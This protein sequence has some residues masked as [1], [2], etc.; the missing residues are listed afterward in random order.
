M[1]NKKDKRCEQCLAC[2]R[3]SEPASPEFEMVQCASQHM[4]FRVTATASPGTSV[5]AC[6]PRPSSKLLER[7]LETCIET[8]FPMGSA[9]QCATI[10]KVIPVLV[11]KGAVNEN[12]VSCVS[13]TGR[14][15]HCVVLTVKKMWFL[16]SL[17]GFFPSSF[18][19]KIPCHVY[20]TFSFLQSQNCLMSA[21]E[22]APNGHRKYLIAYPNT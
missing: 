18:N 7:S 5:Q 10:W 6:I 14:H 8:S 4:V 17:K 22:G 20:R 21:S 3:C 9:V 12:P 11:I 2:I 16:S 19:S 13:S 15:I 1:K